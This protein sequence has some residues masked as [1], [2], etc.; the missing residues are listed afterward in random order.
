MDGSRIKLHTQFSDEQMHV[1][2]TQVVKDDRNVVGNH[3]QM[4]AL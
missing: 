2:T 4:A 1:V 3:V